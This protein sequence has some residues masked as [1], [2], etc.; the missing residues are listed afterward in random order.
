ML[1]NAR[2]IDPQRGSRH[3]AFDANFNIADGGKKP[4]LGLLRYFVPDYL[5]NDVQKIMNQE[6]TQAFIVAN[7]CDVIHSSCIND[8]VTYN[9][10]ATDF[11]NRSDFPKHFTGSD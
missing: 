7:V 4:T 11:R 2:P 9:M 10:I 1:A 8:S 6:F 3:L 5:A